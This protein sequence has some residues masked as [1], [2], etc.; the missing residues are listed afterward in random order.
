MAGCTFH[1]SL[2]EFVADGLLLELARL[3]ACAFFRSTRNRLAR[4]SGFGLGLL[5]QVA[6]VSFLAWQRI[7]GHYFA[8][9]FST[10]NS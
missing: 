5:R 3:A 6:C 4:R 7:A 9:R 8:D 1:L 10:R 2:L